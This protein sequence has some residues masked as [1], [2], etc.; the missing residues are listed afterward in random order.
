VE[1][2]GSQKAA[3]F[4][5]VSPGFSVF[6]DPRIARLFPAGKDKSGAIAGRKTCN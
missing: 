6:I 4:F 1:Y 3:I 5:Q 2:S